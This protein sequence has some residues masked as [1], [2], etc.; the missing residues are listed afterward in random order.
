MRYKGIYG[1]WH[2][3][4]ICQYTSNILS[5]LENAWKHVVQCHSHKMCPVSVNY[6]FCLLDLPLSKKM[7]KCLSVIVHLSVSL[8]ISQST[9]FIY[10]EAI[11]K[12][13][14]HDL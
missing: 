12:C 4:M 13:I 5:A 6:Y 10:F 3:Y 11:V 8:C 2:T 1:I 7:L 14:V 9:C